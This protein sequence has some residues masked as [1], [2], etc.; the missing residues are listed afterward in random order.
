MLENVLNRRKLQALVKQQG[1]LPP[2]QWDTNQ[3]HRCCKQHVPYVQTVHDQTPWSS[4]CLNPVRWANNQWR[5]LD[6]GA[7]R[8][9]LQR[10]ANPLR[11]FVGRYSDC[12][13]LF[14]DSHLVNPPNPSRKMNE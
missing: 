10:L 1:R 2:G 8:R 5:P 7:L 6:A 13:T 9:R 3:A 4:E 11:R 14:I 12:P